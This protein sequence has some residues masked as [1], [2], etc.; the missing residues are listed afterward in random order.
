MILVTA[1]MSEWG[2][3]EKVSSSM[4]KR[5]YRWGREFWPVSF[6]DQ[7][8]FLYH[9]GRIYILVLLWVGCN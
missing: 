4:Y 2:L 9:L 1:C 3:E 6:S 7:A 8:V 5:D